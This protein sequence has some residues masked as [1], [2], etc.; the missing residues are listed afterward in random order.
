[1]TELTV[2]SSRHQHL[3]NV[4]IE[5]QRQGINADARKIISLESFE[6][7]RNYPE[8]LLEQSHQ[9]EVAD[10]SAK[11]LNYKYYITENVICSKTTQGTLESL[12]NP[13]TMEVIHS[14]TRASSRENRWLICISRAPE[15]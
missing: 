12:I 13:N 5:H 6:G 3:Y 2:W 7:P 11:F 14:W 4:R 15:C 8:A 10:R 9:K 1:M